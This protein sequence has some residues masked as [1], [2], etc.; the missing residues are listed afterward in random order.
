[1]RIRNLGFLAC[2][3]CAF[4]GTAA[5]AQKT[6]DPEQ[7][8]KGKT[9]RVIVGYGPGGGYDVYGRLLA[10]HLPRFLPGAPLITV[11]YMPGAATEVATAYVLNAAPQDGTVI[12]IP[13]S[14][15]PMSNLIFR[16]P[17]EGGI[18]IARMRWIGRLDSIDMV[19]I[20]W[21]ETGVSKVEDTLGR[22]LAFGATATTSGTYLVPTILNKLGKGNFK[23]VLGYRGTSDAYLAMERREIDGIHNGVWSQLKRSRPE[24]LRTNKIN[25]I[26]QT[27][28]KR[29]TDLANIPTII[30][31]ADNEDDRRMFS[32]FASEATLG[33]TFYVSDNVPRELLAALR[34]AFWRMATD[35]TFLEAAGKLD[36][37]ID[38]LP[39]EEIE[40]IVGNM[41]GYSPQI[42]ERI[43]HL[44]AK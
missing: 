18:D 7:F 23:L 24:W 10:D 11:Q 2:T 30:E 36:T 31:L 25:V 13:V 3:F 35:K 44:T 43:R 16:K 5:H 29:A 22:P 9:M 1:M 33:R 14:S 34:Q 40:K 32:L 19:S 26:Y 8:Y 17:G 42:F 38:P 41:L 28:A 21:G 15:L 37:P 6:V 12:G 27:A 39:G 4:L 20:V